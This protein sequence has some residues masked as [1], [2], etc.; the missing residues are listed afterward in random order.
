M[1]CARCQADNPAGMKFCGQCGARLGS[2]CAACGAENPAEFRFCGQC[3]APL[4]RSPGES[5]ALEP[6]IATPQPSGTVS[7]LP[8]ELK[9]VTVLFCDIVNSTP[10]TVRL[11]AEGMRDLVHQFLES[12]LAEVRRYGGTAPQFTG[13]GFMALFGAPLTHEDHVRRALLAALAI[14]RVLREG[15]AT[16]DRQLYEL[17]LRIGIHTGP[18]VFGPVA[19]NLAMDYTVI[20]DTANVAAR[21]QQAAA[22][23]T[24]LIS[25]TTRSLAEGYARTEPVG[26]L[27]LKGKA[28]PVR[29]YSLLEVSHRRAGLREAPSPRTAVFVDR[30]SELAI[31]NNFLR[32]VESG[33][34]QAV[35]LV[36]E[37]GIGKSRLLGEFRRQVADGRASWIEGRCLS[38]GTAIPYLLALDLLRS[39]CGILEGDAPEVVA[40]RLRAGLAEVGMDPDEHG[41]VL[42][43]LLEIKDVADSPALSNPE[44]VKRR[45][46]ET[47]R[48]LTLQRSLQGP[49][50]LEVEDLHWVDKVSE[51]FLGFLAERVRDA[52]VLLLATYRPGYRPPWIDKSYAGQTPLQRLSQDDSIRMVRSVLQVEQLVDL[53]T[54]E[55]VA[56]ADGNPLFLEQLALHAGEARDLRTD[57]MVP[58]TIHDVVMARIDRLPEPAKRALQLAAV[59]GREFPMAL[60]QSVWRR[61]EPL[62]DHLR[63][64]KRLEFIYE[65]VENE[66]SVYVFRHALTQETAYGSLLERHRRIYHGAVGRALEE[67]YGGRTDE[68][69]ELLALHFGRSTEAEKS[70]DYAIL[71]GKKSQRRWANNEALTYFNDALHTLDLLPDTE[72]NRLHRIDAVIEQAEVKF[73]LGQHAEHIEALDQIAGLV[74]QADDPRR[75]ATWHYWRGFLGILT[76]GQ[77]DIAIDHCNLAAKLAADAGLDEIKA[78][79]ESCLAEIYLFTGR[80]RETIEVG[81]RALAS[82]EALGNLWWACRTIWRLNPAAMA[83]GEWEAS[84]SY[85]RRALQYGE[86]LGDL[87]IKVVGLW[88]MG[89]TYVYQG[90]PQTAVQYCDEALA[91]GALPFDAAMAKAVRGYAKIKLGLDDAGITDLSEC[92]TW[93]EKSRLRYT[94]ARYSLLLAE[95]LLRRGDRSAARP[96]I[97]GLLQTSRALGY[98]HFEGTACWLMGECLAPEAPASAEPHVEIAMDILERIGARNDLARAMVTRAALRQAAGDIPAARELLDRAYAILREL[99]TLDE[100]ARVEAGRAALDRGEPIHFLH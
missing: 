54:Q 35:G 37:P 73:A 56:K 30:E 60:L 69:A 91:L 62:E 15:G 61:P 99:G 24:I 39:N 59:I 80:L 19:D 98:L 96:L 16:A 26:P 71:A 78:D 64:L 57:L 21:L 6:D 83:L 3:G 49:L 1:K 79:A 10:L 93:F 95:G 97:E 72:S 86:V 17:E 67:L 12:S 29:A 51:E 89:A 18:V 77:P 88:R 92:V 65:R 52:R 5:A 90:D 31:L 34:G 43:H 22:P 94:N 23:G 76:G 38:Y 75:R 25:E 7:T 85:C 4:D 48:E 74:D 58:N 33:H 9:Q 11:G 70:V 40:E 45:A 13:D 66:A 32:Q 20:G 46:F 27:I 28:E 47:L 81:E 68:V 44:A 82:F 42:L 55:I 53:V 63:E 100:P 14:R 41:P 50:I 36:G 2:A 87:R 84:F 8:G